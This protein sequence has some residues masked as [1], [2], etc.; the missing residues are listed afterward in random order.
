MKKIQSEYHNSKVVTDSNSNLY[1]F[2]R[3]NMQMQNL[4]LDDFITD[5]FM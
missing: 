3:L 5:V 1:G 4:H 2:V